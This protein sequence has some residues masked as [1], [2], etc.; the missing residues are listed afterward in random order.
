MAATAVL[1]LVLLSGLKSILPANS[2][3]LLK[4][5]LLQEAC[6]PHLSAAKQVPVDDVNKRRAIPLRSNTFPPSSPGDQ[7]WFEVVSLS[8]KVQIAPYPCVYLG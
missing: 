5:L 8:N 7:T 1:R 6:Y 3:C 2:K 4:L